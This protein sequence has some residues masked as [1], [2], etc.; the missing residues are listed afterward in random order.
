MIISKRGLLVVL[1]FPIAVLFVLFVYQQYISSFSE[2]VVL[3][4]SGYDSRDLISGHYVTF[5]IEYGVDGICPSKPDL[6]LGFICLSPKH[7]SYLLPK[8]CTKLIRGI[9]KNSRFN[10]GIEKYYIPENHAKALEDKLRLKLASI[11]I[12]ITGR[13]H[14]QVKDLLIEGK[15]FKEVFP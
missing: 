4:I 1:A 5:Q 8:N 3:P 7:F 14:A 12:S 15:S 2:E 13:G 11:V 10:A 6:K 9:C